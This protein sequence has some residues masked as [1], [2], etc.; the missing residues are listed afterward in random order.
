MKQYI[1]T[2]QFSELELSDS[3]LFIIDANVSVDYLMK[4]L[5]LKRSDLESWKKNRKHLSGTSN[6]KYE[7]IK[8][9]NAIR[10]ME[11]VTEFI[12]HAFW[13]FE[14]CDG[15]HQKGW[16]IQ[17]WHD[18]DVEAP[19]EQEEELIDTLYELLLKTKE[20]LS[21]HFTGEI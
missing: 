15:V 18:K 17:V 11:L 12:N 6:Y 21:L 4:P 13:H 19:S 8:K 9:L 16:S 2:E 20:Y 1:T 14:K 5:E 10:M 7:M 3:A